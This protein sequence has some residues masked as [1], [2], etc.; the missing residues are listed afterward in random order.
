MKTIFFLCVCFSGMRFF[1]AH[2]G[3]FGECEIFKVSV[4]FGRQ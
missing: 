1:A 3:L 4:I 2:E